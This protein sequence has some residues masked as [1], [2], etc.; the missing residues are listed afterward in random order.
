[1]D[2]TVLIHRAEEGGY[3]AEVADLDGCLVQGETVEQLLED[4][5]KAIAS[6][7]EALREDGQLIPMDGR[8]IVATVRIPELAAGG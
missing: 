2:Y 8:I 1:M 5:P 3:W 6:H 4:A 7:L